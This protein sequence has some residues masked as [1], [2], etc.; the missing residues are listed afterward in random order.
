MLDWLWKSKQKNRET[1]SSLAEPAALYR[2]V[3][4][5]PAHYWH[6]QPYCSLG[7]ITDDGRPGFPRS[8]WR[9][10]GETPSSYRKRK[11]GN[12]ALLPPF[13][14]FISFLLVMLSFS[15]RGLEWVLRALVLPP[16]FCTFV[17]FLLVMVPF[18][19]RGLEWVLR[20]LTLELLEIL[21][22]G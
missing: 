3:P 1:E 4:L 18:S 12:M 6:H 8:L 14:T 7:E 17:S 21:D 11:K 15:S 16:P 9:Q 5:E 20:A 22:K 2:E 19:F 10:S 13:C